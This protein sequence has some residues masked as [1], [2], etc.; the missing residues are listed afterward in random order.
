MDP[1]AIFQQYRAERRRQA[2]TGF[3]LQL[4]PRLSRYVAEIKGADGFVAFADLKAESVSADVQ[5]QIAFFVGLQQSFEWKVYD[6]DSPADLRAILAAF[7]FAQSDEEAFLVADA[8]SWRPSKHE[9]PGLFIQ[10]VTDPRQLRD[11][12]SAEQSI[13]PEH[14]LSW[15]IRKYTEELARDPG[16]VSIYCAYLDEQPVGTGRVSFPPNSAFAELN[17]GGIV[18]SARGRGIFTALLNHRIAEATARGYQWLAVDAAPMSRPILLRKG[19]QH[20][21]WTYPMIHRVQT[22]A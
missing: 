12:V 16:S 13:W 3:K 15:H 8:K 22:H 6:F 9:I 21:C 14:D 4:L 18:A 7:G 20:V 2:Y 5:E 10:R 17:G 1:R 11:F 19:F